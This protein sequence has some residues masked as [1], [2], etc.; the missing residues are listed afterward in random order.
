MEKLINDDIPLFG[1]LD[2][3]NE[4]ALIDGLLDQY[5]LS[6]NDKRASKV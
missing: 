6:I 1:R 4:T 2:D 3:N 5:L